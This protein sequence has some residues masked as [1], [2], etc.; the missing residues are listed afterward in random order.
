MNN[1]EDNDTKRLIKKSYALL[2][3]G[4]REKARIFA[5]KA[6]DLSPDNEQAWLI[7]ASLSKSDQALYY[8]ENALRANPES[9]AAKK[10]IRVIFEEMAAQG[11]KP[12]A[13]DE[14]EPAIKIGDT[15]PIPVQPDPESK[16]DIAL[17]EAEQ[18]SKDDIQ[19]S[20]ESSKSSL[21]EKLDKVRDSKTEKTPSSSPT[22]EEK[23]KNLRKKLAKSSKAEPRTPEKAAK[24]IRLKKKRAKEVIAPIESPRLDS[25]PARDKPQPKTQITREKESADSIDITTKFDKTTTSTMADNLSRAFSKKRTE[26]DQPVDQ[27]LVHDV[28]APKVRTESQ[29]EHIEPK[30]IPE[31]RKKFTPAKKKRKEKQKAK[32][33]PK[34]RKAIAT[35][36]VDIVELILVSLAA[37]LLPILAFLYFLIKK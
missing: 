18:Q 1:F 11:K 15:S 13:L 25:K 12:K 33:I 4:D 10:G 3:S 37:V 14:A 20:A 6:A 34:K 27:Q 24:K 16:K 7:L 22:A 28:F 19:T 2:K 36:D 26:T 17:P 30:H 9:E 29:E 32:R 5:K 8:L 21:K 35:S 23:K 31:T